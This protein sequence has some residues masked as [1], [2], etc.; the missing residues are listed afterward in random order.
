MN[1]SEHVSPHTRDA[2]ERA[3]RELGY[4]PNQAARALKTRRTDTVALVRRAAE[5][6]REWRPDSAEEF[7]VVVE[8][9]LMAL[10]RIQAAVDAIV[11]WNELD[12]AMRLRGSL[13]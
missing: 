1:G 11:P 6:L 9:L 3:V 7:A 2:V 12:R 8:H 10:N 5:A 4:V 13:G